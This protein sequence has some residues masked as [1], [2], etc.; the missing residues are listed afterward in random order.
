M[1]ISSALALVELDR[2]GI[3]RGGVVLIG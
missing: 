2:R 3:L 1:R